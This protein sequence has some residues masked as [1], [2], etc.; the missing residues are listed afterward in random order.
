MRLDHVCGCFGV[1]GGGVVSLLVCCVVLT[2]VYS[3]VYLVYPF[4]M[5][6]ISYDVGGGVFFEMWL[7]LHVCAG[8]LAIGSAA[9]IN[10][11]VAPML[12]LFDISKFR[13]STFFESS[14]ARVSGQRKRV[15]S[16]LYSFRIV[17]P[18]LLHACFRFWVR[19]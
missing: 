1:D 16:Q 14:T 6:S 15:P 2:R 5:T 12:L 3:L 8:V 18:L 13:V 10:P 17:P 4:F 7:G 11:L 19:F 9:G